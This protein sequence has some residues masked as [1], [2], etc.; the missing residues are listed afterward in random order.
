MRSHHRDAGPLGALNLGDVL[1]DR[2]DVAGA[3]AAYEGAVSSGHGTAAVK[4]A[5]RLDRLR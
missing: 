1:R 5:D 2:G 3:R 4:A